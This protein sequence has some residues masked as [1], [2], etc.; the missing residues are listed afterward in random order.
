M[1][2]FFIN[3]KDG[4]R[5]AKP[6]DAEGLKPHLKTFL[7]GELWFNKDEEGLVQHKK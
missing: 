1:L 4:S 2:A 6:I 7:L 3:E 5:S